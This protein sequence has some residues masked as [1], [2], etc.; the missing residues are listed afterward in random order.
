MY[1]T[2]DRMIDDEDF[3]EEMFNKVA[4]EKRDKARE[5]FKILSSSINK[6]PQKK[7]KET[8]TILLSEVYV[9]ESFTDEERIAYLKNAKRKEIIIKE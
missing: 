9:P 3:R 8:E 5:L 7:V 2:F 6:T 1:C 4:P